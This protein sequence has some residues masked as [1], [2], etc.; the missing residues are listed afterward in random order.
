MFP[1]ITP[2][3]ETPSNDSIHPKPHHTKSAEHRLIVATIIDEKFEKNEDSYDRIKTPTVTPRAMQGYIP[4]GEIM[5]TISTRK[6]P[7]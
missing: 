1:T 6:Q 5:P 4:K 7:P 2:N 3:K